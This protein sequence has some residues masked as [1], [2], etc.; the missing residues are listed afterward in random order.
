MAQSDGGYLSV[1]GGNRMPAAGTFGCEQRI[2]GGTVAIKSKT[3][4][5]KI[6]V[7][8]LL[9]GQRKTIAATPGGQQRDAQQYLGARN[10]ADKKRSALLLFKPVNYFGG[11]VLA[12]KL[13]KNVGIEQDAAHN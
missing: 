5:G 8:H 4:A 10:S 7:K 11:R 9:C 13:R 1:F 6:L 2:F 3:V 12:H